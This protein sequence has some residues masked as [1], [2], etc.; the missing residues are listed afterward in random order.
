MKFLVTATPIVPLTDRAVLDKLADWMRDQQ[1]AGR[2][3]AAYGLVGGGGC[4]VMDVASPE[5]LHELTALCPIGAYLSFDIKPLIDLDTS[6]AM[7][8]HQLPA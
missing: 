1:Q 3:M 7:G 8:R 6:F 4:S 5:E 2:I